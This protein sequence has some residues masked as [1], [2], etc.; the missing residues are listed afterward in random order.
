MLTKTEL[1][2]RSHFIF[3]ELRS[4]G[5]SG[6]IAVVTSLIAL[7]KKKENPLI[8]LTCVEVGSIPTL[9]NMFD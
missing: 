7:V 9:T 3:Q 2:S 8:F 5:S 6:K 1:Q 4:P